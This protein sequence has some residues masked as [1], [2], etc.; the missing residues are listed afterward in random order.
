MRRTEEMEDV[1]SH[2]I[3]FLFG[4][5]TGGSLLYFLFRAR[6]ALTE[7]QIRSLQTEIEDS[8]K[9]LFEVQLELKEA[10]DSKARAE[11][12][13]KRLPEIEKLIADLREENVNLKTRVAELTK[14]KELDSE[15]IRWVEEAQN[16]LREV[17]QALAS[18]VL[19]SSSEEFLKYTRSQLETLLTQMKGDLS[20][21]KAEFK[22]IVEPLEA[23]LKTLDQYIRDL[24]RKREGAYQGL[25]EQL[26]QLA[27]THKELH[28][29]TVSLVQ[30]LK[31]P[32][33]RGKWGEY[34]LR[35]LV[36]MAGMVEH[37][38][39]KEQTTSDHRR[40]D[41]IIYLPNEGVLA[42][43][44][45]TPMQ[46]YLEA[47][48][49]QD[50]KTRDAKLSDHARSLKER[51]KELSDKEY[52]QR[53][54]KAPEFVIMFVPNEA[55]LSSAFERDPS[56]LDFAIEKRVFPASPLSLLALLKA[57]AFGWQQHRMVENASEIA[58]HGKQLCERLSNFLDHLIK[59]GESL[60]GAVANYNKT[61]GS[62]EARLLPA[63][64]KLRDLCALSEDT[65]DVKTIDIQVRL[66]L[67]EEE[68]A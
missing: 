9:R 58:R 48:E 56:L 61:I 45:K 52:W 11:E 60:S 35:R 6:N 23:T 14:E 37:V 16:R 12:N 67:K 30:A 62:L 51:V 20:T 5:V 34:Q 28:T 64:K 36:E 54:A 59:T 43:D 29:T 2:L 50:E 17:F 38:D 41:M 3:F 55:C 57:I 32:T 40:P 33:V 21:H 7:S 68:S 15:K 26:K 63:A 22:N 42:L 66:P 19:Q 27:Q 24:E 39:F 18:E 65:P 47:L 49:A 31:S 25:Q 46:A 4:L 1:T 44:A 8:K 10:L 13:A 53:F